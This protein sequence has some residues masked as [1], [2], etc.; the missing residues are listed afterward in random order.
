MFQWLLNIYEWSEMEWSESGKSHHCE[1]VCQLLT[2]EFLLSVTLKVVFF[3]GPFKMSFLSWLQ[4]NHTLG[5]GSSN[6]IVHIHF[7]C[8]S[9]GSQKCWCIHLWN[10][11]GSE[12]DYGLYTCQNVTILDGSLGLCK[13]Y[14]F[15]CTCV[16]VW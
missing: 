6:K 11:K 1:L 15:G 8:S 3:Q 2:H 12:K 9:F 10:G 7:Y 14:K 13:M 5:V 16:N 4:T